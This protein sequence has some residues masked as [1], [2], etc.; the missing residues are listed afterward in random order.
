ML[1][2]KKK[3]QIKNFGTIY[4]NSYEML[5]GCPPFYTLT[6]RYYVQTYTALWALVS[7]F[8]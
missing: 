2:L 4:I 7:E 1:I 6:L 5:I 3:S 8:I